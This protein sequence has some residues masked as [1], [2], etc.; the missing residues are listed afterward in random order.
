MMS[1]SSS[2]AISSDAAWDGAS[3]STGHTRRV[4]IHTGHVGRRG[5]DD[6]ETP[7]VVIKKQAPDFSGA[8][9]GSRSIQVVIAREYRNWVGVGPCPARS[10]RLPSCLLPEEFSEWIVPARLSQEGEE[11]AVFCR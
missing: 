9:P 11:P 5:A 1:A 10:L 7:V 6:Q 4:T 3:D 2:L 8:A